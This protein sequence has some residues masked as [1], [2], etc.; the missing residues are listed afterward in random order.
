MAQPT[1]KTKPS[2]G[3]VAGSDQ[4]INPDL[5]RWYYRRAKSRTIEIPGASHSV[6]ESHP[7]EVAAVIEEAARNADDTH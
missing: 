4:I 5:E 2:W 1:V 6:Y 7:K 3:V